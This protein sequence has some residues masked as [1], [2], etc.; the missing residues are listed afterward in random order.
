MKVFRAMKPE[1][2]DGLPEI[3]ET[4]RYLGV[5]PNVDIPVGEDGFVEPVTGGMSV[6]PPP[7]TNLARH[8]LP[9]EMGGT[10]K[11][12][13]FELDTDALPEELIYCSD[14]D[15]PEGHGFIEPSR[16]MSFR[17]YRRL[18]HETRALWRPLRP[19]VR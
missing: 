13:V 7:P 3:G 8:R 2:S 16:Q 6:V 4:G 18:V 12:T 10:G 9:H 15:N 14:P 1:E 11:D 5:R 19:T 17:D